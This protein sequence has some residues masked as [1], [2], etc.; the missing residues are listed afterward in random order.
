MADGKATS[1]WC[2]DRSKKTILWKKEVTPNTEDGRLHV[3]AD[4]S[5]RELW[6]R[7][8]QKEY[9]NGC[10]SDLPTS[11]FDQFSSRHG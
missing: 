2:L 3:P 8:I 11:D 10:G 5:G 6:M 1:L 7:D 9:G 4:F